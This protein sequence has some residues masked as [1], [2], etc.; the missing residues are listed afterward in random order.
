[1]L[2]VALVV[3]IV[4]GY[5]IYRNYKC[6]KI[7]FQDTIAFCD[8]LSVEI[9]FSKNNLGYIIDTYKDSYA[10]HFY[11]TLVGY[12]TLLDNRIEITHGAVNSVVWRGLK[13]AEITTITDFLYELGRH[14]SHEEQ[15]KIASKR[16][17]FDHFFDQSKT[18]LRREA[19]IY[20][21]LCIILGIALVILLV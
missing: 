21:K 13:P 15:S 10:Q 5:Y 18:A 9:G 1:M 3:P 2:L 12:K 7:F 14:G 8:H 19:S 16:V 11:N 4:F 6:R 17:T 20:F